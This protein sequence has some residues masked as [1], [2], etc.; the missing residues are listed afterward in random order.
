MN[1]LVPREFG[2]PKSKA[3]SITYIEC[4][5]YHS[6]AID[7]KGQ[8]WAWGLN[9]FGETGIPQ[10][11]GESGASVSI[12]SIL[13]F[14]NDKEVTCITG[15]AHHSIAV[16]KDGNC[17]TWGRLDGCQLGIDIAKLNKLNIIYDERENPRILT[18]PAA[19]PIKGKAS[20]ATAASD[21]CICITE[22]G[23]AW[24]WGFSANYQT[25]LGTDDD[26]AVA[27]MIDNTAV[28]E[29]KLNWAGCGGQYSIVTAPASESV[30]LTNGAH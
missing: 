3:N 2:L 17:Y 16:T 12:P 22:Q 20:F 7:R 15:G 23:K 26:V 1:G 9:N 6:F 5:S 24:S 8:V 30:A 19:V 25:G 28:R 18:E 10:G 13:E 4:G 29:K 14:F 21:H 27:T 11:S